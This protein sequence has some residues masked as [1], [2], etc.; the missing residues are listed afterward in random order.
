MIIKSKLQVGNEKKSDSI[1]ETNINKLKTLFQKKKV[2]DEVEEVEKRFKNCS[3][4]GI[5]INK[6]TGIHIELVYGGELDPSENKGGRTYYIANDGEKTRES[7]VT[8]VVFTNINTHMNR[9]ELTSTIFEN[10]V[11]EYFFYIGRHGQAQHNLKYATH[12]ITDTDVTVFGQ[13]QAFNAGKKLGE[14]LKLKNEKI[15]YVFA[16]DLMRTRQTIQFM[17]DGMNNY[18]PKEIII[19]P[20]SHELKYSLHENC[21]KP[22]SFLLFSLKLTTKENEPKCSNTTYCVDTNIDNPESQCSHIDIHGNKYIPLNWTFYFDYNKNKMRN[23][24]CSTTNM[25]KLAIEIINTFQ[26]IHGIRGDIKETRVM[27]TVNKTSIQ[28]NPNLNPEIYNKMD[29]KKGGKK[30]RKNWIIRKQ[31]IKKT[32]R[33]RLKKSRRCRRRL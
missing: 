10:G 18:I 30:T 9:L 32:K 19:L 21:D 4:L 5:S 15:D 28:G 31:F 7:P 27:M 8:E 20:C 12:L 24:D 1:I 23:M 14:I 29:R 17:L 22:P 6:N 2:N 26:G 3:I 13:Q 16:S 25:I 33:L 11:D